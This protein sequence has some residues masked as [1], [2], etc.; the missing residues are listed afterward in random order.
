MEPTLAHKGENGP[1]DT[2]HPT[3]NAPELANRSYKIPRLNIEEH[4]AQGMK[5]SLA[6]SI[7]ELLDDIDGTLTEFDE[8]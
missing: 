1:I 6:S 4:M 5:T 8:V 3:H 7:L 2:S